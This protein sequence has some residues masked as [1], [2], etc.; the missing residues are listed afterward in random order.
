M[1]IHRPSNVSAIGFLFMQIA[2]MCPGAFVVA[3]FSFPI[4]DR[5]RQAARKK[6]NTDKRSA[7]SRNRRD[8]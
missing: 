5:S 7:A 4:A 3:L 2:F 6:W 1:S 8:A